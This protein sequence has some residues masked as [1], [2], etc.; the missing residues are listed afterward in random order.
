MSVALRRFASAD[1][2][3]ASSSAQG[4]LSA[5]IRQAKFL[6]FRTLS[7]MFIPR[8]HVAAVALGC[9]SLC[10]GLGACGDEPG[11]PT[12]PELSAEEVAAMLA[13]L[14]DEDFAVREAASLRLLAGGESAAAA[15]KAAPPQADPEVAL[16]AAK[17]VAAITQREQ[18]RRLKAFLTN[19]DE[20]EDH[21]LAGWREFR[22]V[23]GDGKGERRFFVELHR[24]EPGLMSAL[25]TGGEKASAAFYE[26]AAELQKLM[27]A[28]QQNPLGGHLW[29]PPIESSAALL[30]AATNSAIKLD[31]ARAYALMDMI[32]RQGFQ[33]ELTGG[34]HRVSLRKMF[35]AMLSRDSLGNLGM[36]VLNLAM[37]LNMEE[38]LSPALKMIE[39]KGASST[40]VYAILAVARFGG[41][42]HLPKLLPLTKETQTCWTWHNGEKKYT[43]Q[44]DD[45]ARAAVLH[46]RGKDVRDFGYPRAQSDSSMVYHAYTLGFEDDKERQT[47][48]DLFD[49]WAKEN[50]KDFQPPQ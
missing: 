40:R 21:G 13:Q 39:D 30:F 50:V 22:Q 19:P 45:I 15:L 6:T 42:A 32:Q 11:A 31:D 4:A 44:I 46:L 9:L 18:Q 17:I 14:G 26:R 25:Q 38:A 23:A 29:E 33:R 7:L 37:Q 3:N 35:A 2:E 12:L 5:R 36:T 16:R 28:R 41:E 27:Q 10:L 47:S 20:A 43:A 24:A 1:A 49:A 34:E 8:I 48:R